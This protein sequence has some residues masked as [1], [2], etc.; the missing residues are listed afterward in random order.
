MTL[1]IRAHGAAGPGEIRA[2]GS[3]D[4]IIVLRETITSAGWPVL[5]ESIGVAVQRGAELRITDLK[6]VA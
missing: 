6:V 3:G 5:W 4:K 1:I 2:C